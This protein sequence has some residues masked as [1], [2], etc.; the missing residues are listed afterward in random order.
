MKG[1]KFCIFCQ[2]DQKIFNISFG[3]LNLQSCVA[4]KLP[5]TLCI[6]FFHLFFISILW[7]KEISM[8]IR[9]QKRVHNLVKH[10]RRSFC[11]NSKRLS[12]VKYFYKKLQLRCLT[13][14]LTIFAKRFFLH[15]WLGSEYTLR[16]HTRE[17]SRI[18]QVSIFFYKYW[19]T[20]F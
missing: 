6:V 14:L 2:I 11:K 20:D 12:A 4:K 19:Q 9:S 8:I 18:K 7:V 13:N 1:W 15:V 5:A 10:L 16:S 3:T 17:L